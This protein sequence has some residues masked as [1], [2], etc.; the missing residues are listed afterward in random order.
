MYAWFEIEAFASYVPTEVLLP[1]YQFDKWTDLYAN[2]TGLL[3]SSA[4]RDLLSVTERSDI[5]SLAGG[6]PYTRDFKLEKMVSATAACMMNQGNDAL[7]YGGSEGHIGLKKH[8]VEMMAVEGI[9]V[10]TE[11]FII[12]GGSQQALDLLGKIFIDPGDTILVE[13]PSYLGALNAFVGYEPKIISVPLDENGMRVDE[14][15]ARLKEL[16][17]AGTKPKFLYLVPNFHNPAGVTL[18]GDR[19]DRI[20]ELSHEHELLIIEDNPYGRLRFEGKDIPS[21]RVQD[22]NVVYLS[23]FSKIF[24]PGIRLGWIM[25]PHPILEKIIFGKQSADLCSSSFTQRVVEEFLNENVLDDYLGELVT[26][27]RGRRDAMLEALEEF[28]PAEA[29]WSRPQ[30]GFFVWAKLPEFIDTTEMLAEAINQ[31]VAYVPGRAFFADG[32]GGN[33]MRLA[34]CYPSKQDV[35]EGIKRLAGVVKD[36]ISLYHSVADRF[37]REKA[38]G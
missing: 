33:F 18:S 11:D 10:G 17:E 36:Q 16:A 24:S 38:E 29:S 6:T 1:K 23:T 12:T 15:E 31:K 9:D 26:T 27:Y 22:E 4:I 19:R 20:I 2:R 8:I 7:Q 21:L 13:G 35:R 32:S 5:I 3:K 28:F 14:L 34:F 25:A 37:G 30:G